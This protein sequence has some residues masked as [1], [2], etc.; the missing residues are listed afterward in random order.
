MKLFAVATLL[1]TDDEHFQDA[2]KEVEKLCR[3]SGFEASK[4]PHVSWHVAE[5]Y[6]MDRTSELLERIAEIQETIT[7]HTVGLGIFSHEKPVL[8]LPVCK[9]SEVSSLHHSLWDQ[10]EEVSQSSSRLYA[11]EKWMP[12]ITLLSGITDMDILQKSALIFSQQFNDFGFSFSNFAVIYKDDLQSGIA[13]RMN[14]GGAK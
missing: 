1:E 2:W 9:T 8:Y 12:H 11:P 4:L 3:L 6:A 13:S 5:A 10:L 14:F 7:G